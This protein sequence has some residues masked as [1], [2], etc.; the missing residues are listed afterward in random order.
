MM[1]VKCSMKLL[2][3]TKI[4]RCTPESNFGPFTRKITH[5]DIMRIEAACPECHQLQLIDGE[6]FVVQRETAVNF[7][8]RSR[9]MKSMVKQVI[10]TFKPIGNLEMFIH[11]RKS[12]IENNGNW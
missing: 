2:M 9:S 5:D 11:I 4:I 8:T 7:Q 10:D 12:Y 3:G 1:F 6:L